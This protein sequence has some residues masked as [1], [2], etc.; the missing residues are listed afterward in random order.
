MPTLE[1]REPGLPGAL[2]TTPD[3][4]AG[5]IPD[6]IHTHPAIVALAW[7]MKGPRRLNV[8]SDAMAALGNPPGRYMLGDQEVTVTE[9]D[10]RLPSGTLAGS[11][12]SMDEALRRLLEYTGC[13]LAE[14]LE[15]MTSTP[16]DLLGIG[17]ERG[18]VQPGA[19]ADLVVL[20]RALQVAATII[21]GQVVPLDPH[22]AL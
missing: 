8:V 4:T 9:R 14:A 2:L 16:A 5:I 12:L 10:A 20:T 3:Q 15:T 18:R 1:H 19:Y 17:H 22:I 11:V 6:G 13:S 7:K 21:E